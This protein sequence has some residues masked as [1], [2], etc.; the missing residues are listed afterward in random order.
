MLVHGLVD[1]V[2]DEIIALRERGRAEHGWMMDIYLLRA[3]KIPAAE[4]PPA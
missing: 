4:T 2:A 3:P 1:D